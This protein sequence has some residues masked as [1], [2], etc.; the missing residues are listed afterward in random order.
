[1]LVNKILGQLRCSLQLAGR[2]VANGRVSKIYNP[3]FFFLVK[4]H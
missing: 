2:P 3:F 1:M 4:T